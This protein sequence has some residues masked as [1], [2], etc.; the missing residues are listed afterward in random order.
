MFVIILFTIGKN[1]IMNFI[2]ISKIYYYIAIT[3]N[4]KSAITWRKLYPIIL[5]ENK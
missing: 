1:K 5:S 3:M 2:I 4:Q